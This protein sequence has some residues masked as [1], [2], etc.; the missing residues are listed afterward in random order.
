MSTFAL[1]HGAWGVA[2]EWDGV[3]KALER[4]GH[5]A[6]A[7]DMPIDDTRAG[8]EDY[9]DCLLRA[10][11]HV[12][13]PLIV[14]GHSAG[15]H[16]AALIPA[17]RPVQKLVF[18]AAFVPRPG[19]PFLVR[20]EGEPLEAAS[21]SDFHLASA[22]F[23]SV[24]VDRGD[25]TCTLDEARLAR[26]LVG[27]RAADMLVPMLRPLLRPHALRAFQ[28]PFPRSSLPD[29]PSEYLLTGADPVLPP[30]SQRVFASRLGVEPIEVPGTDHGVHMKR[31]ALVAHLLSR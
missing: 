31:P 29:V 26:F 7:V 2:R 17:R 13:E 30:A 4:L 20:N 6:I 25:G 18:L 14:V 21:G 5:K 1:V 23:R 8:L 19:E 22:D 11:E 27:E 28:E 24:I 3:I 16:A 12:H 9:A 15:G 10:T